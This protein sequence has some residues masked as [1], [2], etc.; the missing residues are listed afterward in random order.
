MDSEPRLANSED[1]WSARLDA[2]ER[3]LKAS[4]AVNRLPV[5][6]KAMRDVFCWDVA[7][8]WLLNRGVYRITHEVHA[9]ADSLHRFARESATI[10]VPEAWVR[11][12]RWRLHG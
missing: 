8:N 3:S 2:L 4:G 9:D 1:S 6:L 10:A 7:E 12:D 11:P 5:F